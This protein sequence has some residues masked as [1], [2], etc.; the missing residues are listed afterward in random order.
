MRDGNEEVYLFVGPVDELRVGLKSRATRVTWTA[1]ESI[2]SYLAWNG[3]EIGLAWCDDTDGGQHDIY[4]QRQRT[5]RRD[6]KL[7]CAP[8]GSMCAHHYTAAVEAGA[9]F[10]FNRK[11]LSGS[12]CALMRRSRAMFAPYAVAANAP[13]VSSAWPVKF[14]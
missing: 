2:G 7:A 1:G 3:R 13:A 10:G 9:I 11:K 5:F 4:F 14:V 12:Y 6:L 8:A